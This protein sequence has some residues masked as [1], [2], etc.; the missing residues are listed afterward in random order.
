MLAIVRHATGACCGE[1]KCGHT[2][3]RGGERTD[4]QAGPASAMGRERRGVAQIKEKTN[5]SLSFLSQIHSN[6]I[7][8][9][10]KTFSKLGPKTKV[11]QYFILYNIAKRS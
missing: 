3:G 5:F 8:D 9:V 11:D 2:R 4:K 1:S 7:L 6:E 10:F